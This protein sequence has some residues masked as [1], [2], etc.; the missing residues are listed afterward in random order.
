MLREHDN[1][2]VCNQIASRSEL[3]HRRFCVTS[4]TWQKTQVLA[5]AAFDH[6]MTAVKSYCPMVVWLICMRYFN[7]P[8]GAGSPSPALI[9]SPLAPG[10]FEVFYWL[11]CPGT[12]TLWKVVLLKAVFSVSVNHHTLNLTWYDDRSHCGSMLLNRAKQRL[13]KWCYHPIFISAA[14]HRL[15]L[16]E[17][18]EEQNDPEYNTLKT[19]LWCLLLHKLLVLARLRERPRSRFSCFTT[20]TG[21]AHVRPGHTQ[22]CLLEPDRVREQLKKRDINRRRPWGKHLWLAR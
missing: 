13:I 1:Q 21:S 2:W 19:L 8:G 15:K 12:S 7:I 11:I 4:G 17:I 18:I 22:G 14:E 20:S 6:L 3:K 10:S 16:L 5:R 9:S